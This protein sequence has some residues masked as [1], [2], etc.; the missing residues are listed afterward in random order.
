MSAAVAVKPAT[1]LKCP[2]SCKSLVDIQRELQNMWEAMAAG[3]EKPFDSGIPELDQK[4]MGW[5]CRQDLTV[6]AGRPGAGKTAL[7]QQVAEHVAN[8][9]QGVL[10]LSLDMPGRDIVLRRSARRSGHALGM[11]KSGT[12][13]TEEIAN[14]LSWLI[15]DIS[16]TRMHIVDDVFS[17]TDLSKTAD[18]FVA[19]LASMGQKP[20]LVV[21]DHLQK[22]EAVAQNRNLELGVITKELKIMAKRL[23]VPVLALSQLG[24]EVEAQNRKPKKSDLRDSGNIEQDADTILY[25]HRDD[26]NAEVAARDGLADVGSLK[27]RSGAVGDELKLRFDGPT[28]TFRALGEAPVRGAR[29]ALPGMAVAEP[30]WTPRARAQPLWQE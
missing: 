19:W 26:C 1:V 18:E 17:I 8:S 11:L 12:G 10:F 6:L 23:N 24:R 3:L 5:L 28:L 4:F 25:V 22:T 13:V 7:A 30:R 27:L 2:K 21:L 20:G 29:R 14:S 9:G 16:D 15:D